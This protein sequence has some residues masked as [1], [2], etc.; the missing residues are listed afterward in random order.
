MLKDFL[1][2][3]CIV[4]AVSGSAALPAARSLP[5]P[6]FSAD[7]Y[8]TGTEECAWLNWIGNRL[9]LSTMEE[10]KA[11]LID[12]VG[13]LDAEEWGA[14]GVEAGVIKEIAAY[15][16]ASSCK[17]ERAAAPPYSCEGLSD[18][19]CQF[20]DFNTVIFNKTDGAIASPPNHKVVAETTKIRVVNVY[21]PLGT[22]EYR[23]HTHERLSFWI[24][25]G[26]DRGEAYYG[27]NGSKLFDAPLWDGKAEAQ[28]KVMWNGPEWF[29]MIQEKEPPNSLAPGNCPVDIAPAC[30]NG[31]KYRVELKLEGDLGMDFVRPMR[32]SL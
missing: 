14:I 20:S 3:I 5:K 32:F 4:L 18:I 16:N 27:Y 9:D 11:D 1:P 17:R 8:P 31:F 25:H 24:Y 28:L 26:V 10:V 6:M 21:C 19:G 2:L 7:R 23:F 29:H 13:S 12:R 15:L 30:P 22:I